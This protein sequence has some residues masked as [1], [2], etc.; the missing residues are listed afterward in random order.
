MEKFK[1]LQIK[2]LHHKFEKWWLVHYFFNELVDSNYNLVEF[3][4][5]GSFIGKYTWSLGPF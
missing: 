4:S 5:D 1:G 2:C 3:M